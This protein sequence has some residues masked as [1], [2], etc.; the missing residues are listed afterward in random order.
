VE[1]SSFSNCV[2]NFEPFLSQR[3]LI[4]S[5]INGVR[6]FAFA[7]CLDDVVASAALF[8][9][10]RFAFVKPNDSSRYLQGNNL[11]LGSDWG[12]DVTVFLGLTPVQLVNQS[13]VRAWILPPDDAM[14]HTSLVEMPNG[15]SY[16]CRPNNESLD[17]SVNLTN[18]Y[19]VQ[20]GRVRFELHTNRC[21]LSDIKIEQ[22]IRFSIVRR[23][24]LKSLN[25]LSLGRKANKK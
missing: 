11:T 20:V 7:A 17:S 2:C 13:A 5:K 1:K 24:I 15:T 16:I 9:S 12:K 14:N 4:F 18:T 21:C 10:L 22:C 25:K 6:S 19:F 3:L 8:T 23:I